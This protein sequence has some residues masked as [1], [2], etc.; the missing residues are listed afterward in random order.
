M[1]EPRRSRFVTTWAWFFV[2]FGTWKTLSSLLALALWG[3]GSG[4]E[5]APAAPPV[6][7]FPAWARWLSVHVWT[8]HAVHLAAGA[9]LLASAAGLLRHR[10]TARRVLLVLLSLGLPWC[11][12]V[13][14]WQ[15]AVF[16]APGLS[17][18]DGATQSARTLI[19][20]ARAFSVALTLLVAAVLLWLMRRF[21]SPGVRAEFR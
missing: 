7:D 14:A 19:G 2:A 21:S 1:E 8:V 16:S 18:L 10:E 17:P 12:L 9:A 6:P 4:W 15:Q 13:L 11:A 3:L 5:G 20:A